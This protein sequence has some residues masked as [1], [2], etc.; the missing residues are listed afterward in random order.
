[1]TI[2]YYSHTE[3]AY[4]HIK[5]IRRYRDFN[6]THI[7]S[8]TASH[9]YLPHFRFRKHLQSDEAYA[10]ISGRKKN[11]ARLS[12]SIK[13][14]AINLESQPNDSDLI[15]ILRVV[16]TLLTGVFTLDALRL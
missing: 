7:K 12:D 8:K 15:L 4:E 6:R 11:T 14:K 3:N 5:I 9:F 13:K 2:S 10:N 1:M 16:F